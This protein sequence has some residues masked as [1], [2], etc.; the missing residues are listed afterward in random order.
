MTS[1]RTLCLGLA[2]S[3]CFAG[4]AMALDLG[5]A[6]TQGL[7]GET[8]TGYVAAITATPE[9]SALVADINARRREE[10]QRISSGNGQ[11]LNVVETLAAKK[12]YERIAPGEYFRDASGSWKRK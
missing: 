12:L 10:Y 3:L 1:L 11:P 7:V 4:A 9:V 5:S 6:K 2:A 8:P